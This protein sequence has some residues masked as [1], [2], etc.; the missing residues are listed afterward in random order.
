MLWHQL[1]RRKGEDIQRQGEGVALLG[2]EEEEKAHEH[3]EAAN[4]R[5]FMII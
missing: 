1:D 2:A 4:L 5:I 3:Q